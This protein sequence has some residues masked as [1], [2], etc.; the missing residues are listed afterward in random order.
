MCEG[1]WAVEGREGC[2]FQAESRFAPVKVGSVEVSEPRS[3]WSHVTA[4]LF[5]RL[6]Y[7]VFHQIL[8]PG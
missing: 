6:G 2:R 8:Y 5:A 1:P 4:L 3:A 7:G